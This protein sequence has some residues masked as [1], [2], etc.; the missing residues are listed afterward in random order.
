MHI[1][2]GC[3][4]RACGAGAPSPDEEVSPSAGGGD[5]QSI[6]VDHPDGGAVQRGLVGVERAC[7]EGVG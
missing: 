1:L 6:H 4:V 5:F 3:A 7:V 2:R